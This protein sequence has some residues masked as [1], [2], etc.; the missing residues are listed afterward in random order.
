MRYPQGGGLTAERRQLPEWLRLKA[1]ER[2][3]Q[4]ETSSVIAKDLRVSVRSVQRWRR[5]W[6][7]GG[8][9]A[10]R[11]QG[12]ASFPRLSQK[13]FIQLEAELSKGPA[14]LQ[15]RHLRQATSGAV[16]RILRPTGRWRWRA[17]VV[18]IRG[19]ACRTDSLWSY[20]PTSVSRCAAPFLVNWS[21]Q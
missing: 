7:E 20:S 12:P 19:R 4:G 17:S 16:G 5:M 11:S 13:Q 9:R 21:A 3:A 2:F 18:T 14:A 15:A 1:A 6:D 8:P 10:L